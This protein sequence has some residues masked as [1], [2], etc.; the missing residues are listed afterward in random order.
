MLLWFPD[1]DLVPVGCGAEEGEQGRRGGGRQRRDGVAL[2][3]ASS[4]LAVARRA[5]PCQLPILASEYARFADADEVPRLPA[6]ATAAV[7]TLSD[8]CGFCLQPIR[9]GTESGDASL[10]HGSPAML[11]SLEDLFGTPALVASGHSAQAAGEPNLARV[12]IDGK[13]FHAACACVL[14][15]Q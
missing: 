4:W 6:G 1:G 3:T 12:Y 15:V 10:P 2:T 5:V 8:C 13:L 7:A 14:H 11:D 9:A